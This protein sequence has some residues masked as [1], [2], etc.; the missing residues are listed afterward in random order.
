MVLGLRREF[1]EGHSGFKEFWKGEWDRVCQSVKAHCKE[2]GS[3]DVARL[4]QRPF[5]ENKKDEEKAVKDCHQEAAGICLGICE[6]YCIARAGLW[7]HGTAEPSGPSCV[8]SH[9][10]CLLIRQDGL[11]QAGRE[12][13]LVTTGG[14]RLPSGSP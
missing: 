1:L 10:P 14:S 11:T 12:P 5:K 7:G 13:I 6:G 4:G 3:L 9:E 8:G 2:T